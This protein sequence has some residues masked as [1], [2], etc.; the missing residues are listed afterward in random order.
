MAESTTQLYEGLFLFNQATLGGSLGTAM[1]TLREVL[2][3]AEAEVIALSKWD[4]RR[5]AYEIK[6][7]KRGLYLLAHFRARGSQVANIERDVTLSEQ[8]L[9][10]LIL[11][12]D[13]LGEAELELARQAEAQTADAVA[14]AG[15][16]EKAE[17]AEKPVA[18]A[19]ESAPAPKAEDDQA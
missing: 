17:K 12:A 13:H 6:G 1:E 7:Q 5:L 11:R 16:A 19:E 4:E 15:E 2:A 3:R 9:R 14:V 18:V 10:C 8:F